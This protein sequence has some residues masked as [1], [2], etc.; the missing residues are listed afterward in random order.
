M[1]LDEQKIFQQLE[2]IVSMGTDIAVDDFGTGYSSLS[3]LKKY[4]VQRLKIDKSFIDDL[5]SN[6]DTQSLVSGMISLAD[7]LSL[8]TVVEGVETQGQ[9]DLLK[10]FGSPM[11]QGYLLARP[12]TGDMLL[13]LLKNRTTTVVEK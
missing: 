11:I 9:L 6:Q 5:E 13:T 12:M 4:P 2:S 1:L 10:Q 3:Y 7:S 8:K